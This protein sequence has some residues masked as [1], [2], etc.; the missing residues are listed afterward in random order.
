MQASFRAMLGRRSDPAHGLP[1]GYGGAPGEAGFDRL[2]SAAQAVAV[3]DRDNVPIHD[4]A[5]EG[6]YATGGGPHLL[7]GGRPEVYAAVATQPRAL[8]RIEGAD[9]GGARRE[10]PLPPGANPSL[11]RLRRRSR[12]GDSRQEEQEWEDEAGEREMVEHRPSLSRLGASDEPT[13]PACGGHAVVGSVEG[14][15]G[16]Q[17]KRGGGVAL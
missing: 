16:G 10:R 8:G 11:V 13:L 17:T 2:E 9:D 7:P 3:V 4:P 5:H 12:A 15:R 14:Q 6:N 1:G